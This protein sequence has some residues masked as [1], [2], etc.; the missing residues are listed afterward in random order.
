MAEYGFTHRDGPT[1]DG[2]FF[3]WSLPNW[4]LVIPAVFTSEFVETTGYAAAGRVAWL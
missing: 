1:D 4:D 2:W 3:A